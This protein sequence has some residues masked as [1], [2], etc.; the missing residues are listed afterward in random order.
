MY[1]YPNV[2][3]NFGTHFKHKYSVE[4]DTWDFNYNVVDIKIIYIFLS[5]K[6]S[7]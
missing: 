1:D 2:L 3:E 7:L 4:T 5:D 6:L